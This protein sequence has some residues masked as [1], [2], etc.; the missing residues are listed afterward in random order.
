LSYTGGTQIS[1]GTLVVNDPT[2]LGAGQVVTSGGELLAGTTET[3]NNHLA[4]NGD[5]TVA[6]AAGQ[7]LTV[8]GW[9][10]NANGQTIA[11]GSP[12]QNGTVALSTSGGAAIGNPANGYTVLVQAGTLRLNDASSPL[13]LLNDTHTTIRPAGTLDL[14]GFSPT[15][16]D[17][18]GGGHIINGGGAAT[19]TVNGGNF[20]GVIGGPLSL[21]VT[22][23]ST[24][25][26]SGNN[27]YIGGT[28]V[29]SGSTLARSPTAASLQI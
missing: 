24:L 10:I 4:M 27:T 9:N 5:F 26:L 15:V 22:N 3:I 25:T 11:F 17:L 12:G 8:T 21:T 13:L 1:A 29:N 14:N 23:A 16:N 20:S 28:T 7:T 6:A 19:L 2:A 18:H